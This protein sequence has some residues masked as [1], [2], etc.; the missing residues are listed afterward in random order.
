LSCVLDGYYTKFITTHSGM[1]HLKILNILTKLDAFTAEK[2]IPVSPFLSKP[3]IKL[4]YIL[5]TNILVYLFHF[6][7]VL[8]YKTKMLT[9]LNSSM[10]KRHAVVTSP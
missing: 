9:W 10:N 5:E 3:T 4:H 7:L 1:S 2:L 6:H 8:P